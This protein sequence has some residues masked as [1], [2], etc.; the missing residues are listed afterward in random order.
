MIP[1]RR[2]KANA[3]RALSM[4]ADVHCRVLLAAGASD[5]CRKH[6]GMDGH[7]VRLDSFGESAARAAAVFPLAAGI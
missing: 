7:G 3:I 2:H 6:V 1:T 4:N 5:L